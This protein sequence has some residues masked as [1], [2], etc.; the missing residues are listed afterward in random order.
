[1]LLTISSKGCIDIESLF[2]NSEPIKTGNYSSYTC[3]LS[4]SSALPGTYPENQAT[5]AHTNTE[6][7]PHAPRHAIEVLGRKHR[8]DEQMR[9]QSCTCKHYRQEATRDESRE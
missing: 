6:M 2:L 8:P 5:I 9:S 3:V 7:L 1:M 4:S